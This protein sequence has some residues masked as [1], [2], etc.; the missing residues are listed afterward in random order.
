M[1]RRRRSLTPLTCGAAGVVLIATCAAAAPADDPGDEGDLAGKTAQQISD[2]ALH[3]LLGAHSLRLRT[4]SSTDAT[5]LDLTL[6]R[7]GNCAGNVSKGPL[8]RVD[9]IKH[10]KDVWLKPDAAF[11]KS[12]LPG[13]E[14]TTAARNYQGRFLHGT[15]DDAFLQSIATACDLT[16][17]QKSVAPQSPAP[18]DPSSPSTSS[19]TLS[20]GRPTTHEGTRVLPVVKKVGDATQTVYVAIQGTHYPL[21]LTTQVDGESSTVLL[22]D[23]D[24]PVPAHTP[25]PGQ[26]ADISVLEGGVHSA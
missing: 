1:P 18:Q 9:L 12:Q 21:K 13:D 4:A 3:A 15:T 20:K 7:A 25:P 26:T 11:W 22:S 14:G 10:G 2:D 19:V 24:H 16:A 6:D 17:F 23:Y 5:K 8:G